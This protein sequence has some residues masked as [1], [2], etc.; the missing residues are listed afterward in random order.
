MDINRNFDFVHGDPA[1]AS[2]D[3][4]DSDYHGVSPESEPETVAVSNYA[5]S[6][7]PESQRKKNPEAQWNVPFGEDITGL[8]ADIHSSGGYVY[9]PWGHADKVSPDDEALQAIGRKVNSF[10]NYKIWAG[11]Q[12]DFLYPASGDASDYMYG[13]L[14]VAQSAV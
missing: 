12:P 4:C 14:G 11:G 9:Y 10:N 6:I 8:Y 3:P 13:V 2:N 1:G 7:F 5:K